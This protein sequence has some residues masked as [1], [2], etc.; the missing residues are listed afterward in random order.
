MIAGCLLQLGRSRKTAEMSL[1][2]PM[3]PPSIGLQLGRSRKTA[4][5]TAAK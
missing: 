4:E 2:S 1:K 5:M 3:M